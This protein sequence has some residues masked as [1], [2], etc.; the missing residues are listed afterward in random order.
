MGLDQWLSKKTYVKKWNHT[1][2]DKQYHVVVTR[3]G[4]PYANINPDKVSH[5]QEDVAYWRKA[6]Q[7]HHWFVK[8]IQDGEDDCR[9]YP[10]S[11][12]DLQSLLEVCQCVK[13]EP[14]D[15]NMLLPV[16]DG[17]FYGSQ[18]FDQ[19]YFDQIDRTI[20][21]LEEI[22][23]NYDQDSDYYYQASW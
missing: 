23:A 15:A 3:G 12:E 11:K 18:E 8:N 9:E 22:L 19:Y 17:F 13:N 21:V 5:I 14:S 6:N 10:V 7:I 4:E 2:A 1:P 16:S 20:E